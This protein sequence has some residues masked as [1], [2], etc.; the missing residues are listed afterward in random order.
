MQLAMTT[1]LEQ[2]IPHAN[3]LNIQFTD[4]QGIEL[5]EESLDYL[6]KES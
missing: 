3:Y 4:E 5:N 2:M 1:P 6:Y